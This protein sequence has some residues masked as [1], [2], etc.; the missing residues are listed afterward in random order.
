[1]HLYSAFRASLSFTYD[2]DKMECEGVEPSFLPCK[3][4]VLPLDE[5]PSIALEFSAMITNNLRMCE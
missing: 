1:M 2:P 4:N 3:S 5:H